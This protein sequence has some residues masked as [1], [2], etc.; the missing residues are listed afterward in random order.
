M[1][2]RERKDIMLPKTGVGERYNKNK[3]CV[4]I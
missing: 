2:S 4:T 1:P 3:G